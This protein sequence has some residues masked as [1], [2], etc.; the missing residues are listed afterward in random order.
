M[1]YV[2]NL[3]YLGVSEHGVYS[4][5]MGTCVFGQTHATTFLVGTECLWQ[6]GAQFAC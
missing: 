3:I 6:A 2:T 1:R 5:L 4:Q